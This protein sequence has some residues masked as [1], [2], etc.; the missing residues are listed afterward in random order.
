MV[1]VVAVV[2]KKLGVG[3]SILRL[4]GRVID[5][6]NS[7]E[8]DAISRADEQRAFAAE[9]IGEP[10]VRGEI[11]R[12][13]RNFAGRREQRIGQ[14]PAVVKVCRSQRTP[15][16]TDPRSVSRTVS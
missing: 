9:G 10:G 7:H 8:E 3:D 11:I 13:K 16:L 5:L 4:N 12:L 14:Q 1:V 6:R 2:E 15:R